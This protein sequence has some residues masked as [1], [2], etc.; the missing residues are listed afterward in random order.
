MKVKFFH[1]HELAHFDTNCRL[2][3]FKKKSPGG[4]ASEALVSQL[5]LD[6][7]FIACMV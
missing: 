1:C 2:K 4:V 7:S 3:K 6:F 5:D